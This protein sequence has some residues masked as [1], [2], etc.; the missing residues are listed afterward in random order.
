[1][2]FLL[3]MTVRPFSSAL[4]CPG[5]H[6]VATLQAT[7]SRDLFLFW[8]W[9]RRGRSGAGRLA[10]AARM[11]SSRVPAWP[12]RPAWLRHRCCCRQDAASWPWFSRASGGAPHEEVLPCRAR[13]CAPPLRRCM[14]RRWPSPGT[15]TRRRW[16]L[17][18][19]STP[20]PSQV[21]PLLRPVWSEDAVQRGGGAWRSAAGGRS[22][23]ARLAPR[24]CAWR[25][26]RGKRRRERARVVA[27]EA[28]G[29]RGRRRAGAR[30]RAPFLAP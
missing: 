21:R 14:R 3:V 15:A 19:R 9:C 1:M 27:L 13:A 10:A 25:A 5:Q 28:P 2:T 11:P 29:G 4:P 23:R 17:A 24:S 18:C 6:A 30:A 26:A 8:R 20:P 16:P 7:P 12:P 22:T